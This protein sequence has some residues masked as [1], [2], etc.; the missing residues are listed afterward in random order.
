[1][2]RGH[3]DGVTVGMLSR[4]ASALDARFDPMLRWRGGDLPALVNGRHSAMHERFARWSTGIPG[5]SWMPEVSFSRFGE[6]GVMDL[7]GWHEASGALLVGEYKSELVDV[8]E[9]LGSL[10]RKTRLAAVVAGE[11]GLVSSG[12][13]GSWLM[14]AP[15]RTNARRIADHRAVIHLALPDDLHDVLRW[16]RTPVGRLRAVSYLPGATHD[17]LRRRME[18]PRRVRRSS[19]ARS[20]N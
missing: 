1:M 7:L 14:I 9:T 8:Q 17:D 2:E 4:V 13:V 18:G 3:L 12:I 19:P 16:L 11:R 10:D 5:W 15:G 20:N 6:R